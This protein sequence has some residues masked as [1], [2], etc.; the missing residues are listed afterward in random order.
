MFNDTLKIDASALADPI[1]IT[2]ISQTGA[3]LTD[4]GETLTAANAQII[5]LGNDQ[6]GIPFYQRPNTSAEVVIEGNGLQRSLITDSC[7]LCPGIAQ[8]P[9]MNNWRLILLMGL[10]MMLF[11]FV[12]I[13]RFQS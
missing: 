13:R 7:D 8:L 3:M 12:L 1:N 2:F 11:S 10:T 9:A 5:D 6:F 4:K